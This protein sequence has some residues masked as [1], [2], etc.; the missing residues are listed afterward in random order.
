M[1]WK[2][3]VFASSMP[4]VLCLKN[5]EIVGASNGKCPEFREFYAGSSLVL[6]NS[7]GLV[8]SLELNQST[9]HDQFVANK[10][11]NQTRAGVQ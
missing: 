10:R 4:R 2:M 8:G 1:T 11:T 7:E 3:P 6:K 9:L 5:S